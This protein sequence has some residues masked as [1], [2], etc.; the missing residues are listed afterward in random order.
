MLKEERQQ[1]LLDAL[2]RD[3]KVVAV[4]ISAALSVSEDT[5]RR[6]LNEL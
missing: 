5:I 2:K 4:E 1:Q 3:G 6:D